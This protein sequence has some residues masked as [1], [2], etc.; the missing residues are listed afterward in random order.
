M[1]PV[2]HL[3]YFACVFPSL[4]PGCSPFFFLWNGVH[5]LL[6]PGASHSGYEDHMQSDAFHYMH[7][8]YLEV[9]LVAPAGP[10]GPPGTPAALPQRDS[11][12]SSP[13]PTPCPT[14][15]VQLRRVR[16]RRAGRLL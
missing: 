5:L 12:A 10:G 16:R 1:H 7:H 4:L 8:R 3:Y 2:E 9:R 6:S 14:R 15:A 11:F 13:H